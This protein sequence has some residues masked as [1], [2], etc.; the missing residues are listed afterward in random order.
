MPLKISTANTYRVFNVL[1][2][3]RNESNFQ[4]ILIIFQLVL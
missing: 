3:G 1:K 4:I 2:T